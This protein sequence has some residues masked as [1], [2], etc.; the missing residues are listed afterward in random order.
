[1]LTA[2]IPWFLV[3]NSV[4]QFRPLWFASIPNLRGMRKYF[5]T[6]I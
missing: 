5:A 2:L 3:R 1:M 4:R 6:I